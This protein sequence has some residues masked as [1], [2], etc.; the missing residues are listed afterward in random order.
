MELEQAA[1]VGGVRSNGGCSRA[2]DRWPRSWWPSCSWR[3][4]CRPR[5][6]SRTSSTRR[7]R[8]APRATGTRPAP[9][10]APPG[11]A[12]GTA[13]TA[14]GAAAARRGAAAAATA[15][16]T[17]A[18][19]ADGRRA[20]RAPCGGQTE[21]VPGD[22]Y[23]PPC[24]AFSGNNGG[25][26]SPG[27]I[28][29]A[30]NVTYRI[31]VGLAELPADAGLAGWRQHHRHRRRH[32]AHDQRTGHLLRQ[33]LPVLRPQAQHRVLQRPGLHHQRAARQRP[34]AGRRRRRHGGPVAPRLRRAERDVRALRRGAVA[35]EG[36]SFGVP[37]LSA[38]FMGQYAPVHVEPRHRVQ[39]RGRR[40]RA[41]STSSRWP[42]GT[43]PTPA[44]ACRASR[45]RWRSSP[46]ATPGTR[47]PR[48]RPSR[49]RGGRAPGRRQHPVPAEPVDAVQPGR[50]HHQP[51]PER[52]HHDGGLRVR[53][54]DPGRT[55]R[56][57]PP[58][59]ATR[60]S[61]SWPGSP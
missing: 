33:P 25:A 2:T 56:R 11:P 32:P 8:P 44:A 55:S 36:V 45:A 60:P 48:S 50:Q 43:P 7:S 42:A 13:G 18:A 46:R 5:R 20:R 58:S 9:G 6:P 28:A 39:R 17:A 21:Q 34:A 41:S 54:G 3:R 26:T 29:N 27:V 1:V 61:G 22:P 57:G 53:P 49:R 15:A 38:Q 4:W 12:P 16:Q 30:I 51:A 14:G 10:V 24:I 35:A 59:R 23:S 40:R 52:R 31:T 37:Y 19:A 47:P